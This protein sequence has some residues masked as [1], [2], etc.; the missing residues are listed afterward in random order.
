MKIVISHPHGNQNTSQA[1]KSLEKFKLLDTFWT[2]IALPFKIKIFKKK[3]YNISYKKIRIRY[4]KELLRQFCIFFKL[5]KFYSYDSNV[6]SVY[7]VYKDLDFK[8]SKY[9]DLN[10][11]KISAIYTYEDCALNSF[12]SAKKNG[13]KTIYDLTS[14]YWLIKKKIIEDELKLQPGW[15]LSATEKISQDKC[16]NKDKE[17]SLSDKIIV[18]SSFTAKSLELYKENLKSEIKIVPYGVDCPEKNE[19]NKRRENDEFKLIFV[20]RPTLSKGIQYLVQILEKLDFPWKLEIAGSLPENPIQISEKLNSFFKNPRCNFIGQVPNRK[21][22]ERMKRNHLFIF[23]SLFEGFGQVLLEALSCSLP[24]IT[25]VN[26]GGYDIINNG[27][28]GFITPIRDTEKTIEI[29]NNLYQN[30]ELRRSIA[31]NAF[32]KANSFTWSR[33]QNEI[34]K[35]VKI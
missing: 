9:L 8:V 29:L 16:F 15:N 35:I 23:P 32:L 33:Y 12:K 3:F 30:E 7:S 34:N 1:V 6:F 10:K 2:T 28:D 22:I 13:I 14:P 24:V 26:T 17:I 25:T 20:G 31:E 5:K 21:L 27:K 4:V 18:A 19:I 11:N